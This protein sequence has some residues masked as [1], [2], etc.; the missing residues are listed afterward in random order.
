MSLK[1]TFVIILVTLFSAVSA[2]AGKK[3]N[4]PVNE[5][6]KEL[7]K[8]ADAVIRMKEDILERKSEKSAVRTLHYVITVLKKSGSRHGYFVQPYYRYSSVSA[9]KGTLY[10]ASGEKVKT[11]KNTDIS[12]VLGDTESLF[13]DERIKYIDPDYDHYPYTVEYSCEINYSGTINLPSWRVV[14]SYNVSIQSETFKLI[15]P[16]KGNAS[17]GISYYLN[18]KDIPLKIEKT[19]SDKIYSLHVSNIKAYED[20]AMSPYLSQVSPVV[21]FAPVSFEIGGFNGGTRNW[22]EFASFIKELNKGRDELSEETVEKIKNIAA[23]K[24]TWRE[25]VDTLYRYMQNKVRYVLIAKGIQSWQPMKASQVDDVS[26]G[27]CKALTNY[28]K[29]ILKVAGIKSYY[30]LVYAGRNTPPILTNFPS[31]QFNH[32][33]LC[34]PNDGD[35]IWLENTNQN[36]PPGYLGSFTDDRDVL[37]IKNDTSEMVRTIV[38]GLLQN[39]QSRNTD[40]TLF[41]D[42]TADFSIK[43]RSLGMYFDQMFPYTQFDAQKQRKSLLRMIHL[44]TF[45]LSKYSLKA[46]TSNNELPE[47]IITMDINSPKYATTMGN[48]MFLQLYPFHY[49]SQNDFRDKNRKYNFVIKRSNRRIDSVILMV[50]EGYSVAKLP[51]AKEISTDFGSYSY[52]VSEQNGKLVLV[53]EVTVMKGNYPPTQNEEFFKFQ[54]TMNQIDGSK[55]ILRKTN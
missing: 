4:F 55:I 2:F 3:I 53:R 38:Y 50:P 29:S 43:Q 41:D 22:N 34:V 36:I 26:Y 31:N 19:G 25:K 17:D 18:E 1:K 47:V 45:N 30:T 28:M 51:S 15:T 10:N 39:I 54:D 7:L 13:T 46:N 48:L 42:G 9:I 37:V 33:I 23:S 44:P 6:P 11:F 49:D 16:D 32:A 35:T 21:Y 14:P 12:D 24:K 8:N 5:I 52:K 20:E 27:D 40:V